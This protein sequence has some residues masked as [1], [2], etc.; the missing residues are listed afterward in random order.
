MIKR[1]GWWT[2]LIVSLFI[3]WRLAG[4]LMDLALLVVIISALL[5]YRR[6]PGKTKK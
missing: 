6:W 4:V 3:A 1:I 2:L 5:A